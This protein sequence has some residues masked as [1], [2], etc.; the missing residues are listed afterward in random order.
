MYE[1][2]YIFSSCCMWFFACLK[3]FFLWQFCKFKSFYKAPR[4]D[5]HKPIITAHVKQLM[6]FWRKLTKKS[7][8]NYKGC[9]AFRI[10][11]NTLASGR[12]WDLK[13]NA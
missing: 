4:V 2:H 5:L 11:F 1:K 8:I 12:F 13:K 9:I 10:K 7:I 3:I 6:C